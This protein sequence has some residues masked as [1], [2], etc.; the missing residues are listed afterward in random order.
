MGEILGLDGTQYVPS[1]GDAVTVTG[2]KNAPQYN[3]QKGRVGGEVDPKTGR[4]PVVVGVGEMSK[5]L[6][7]LPKNIR[8][9]QKASDREGSGG[10]KSSGAAG[11][12][13]C[14]RM[15][16]STRPSRC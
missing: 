9:V 6:A 15:I 2:L 14:L 4:V 7:L 5:R 11:A 1:A 12:K 16:P 8:L 10:E 13:E 3:G